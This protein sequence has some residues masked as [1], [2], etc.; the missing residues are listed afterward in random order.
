MDMDCLPGSFGLILLGMKQILVRER[1]VSHAV[2]AYVYIY[3]Y[4]LF[5]RSEK[6]VEIIH[7]LFWSKST[8]YM[9]FIKR[10]A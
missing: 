5:S 8:M 9:L 7:V 4:P 2:H 6:V 10:S 1:G 3:L